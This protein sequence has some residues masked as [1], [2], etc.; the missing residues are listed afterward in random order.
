M[1]KKPPA[2]PGFERTVLDS[3]VRVVTETIP[4]VRSIAVGAWVDAGSRDETPDE[5]GITHFIEH[6]VFKGTKRRKGHH[7]NQRMESVGGYLNAFTSKEHTCFYARA[8]DHHLARSLDTTL[9]L[10]TQPTLPPKEVEKEKEVVIEEI[11]MYEDAPEDHIYDH[12]E[13]AMYPGHPLGRPVLGTPETVR[14]FTRDDLA[15]YMDRHYVP[16]RLV[17]SVAGHARHDD[18]VRLVEKQLADFDR[19]PHAVSREPAEAYEPVERAIERPGGQQAHL[20]VGARSFG[21]LDDRRTTLSVLNTILGGGMSSRLN[22]NIREKYGYCYAVYS[23]VN[24]VAETGDVGV[25]MGTDP[26]RLDRARHLIVREL[27]KLAE[28]PVSARMLARA[29]E[30][31]KGSVMLGIESMSNRMQRLGRVELMFER[32]VSLDEALAEVEAVTAEDVR[33]VAAALFAEDRLSTIA[34]VPAEA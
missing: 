1:P 25:Y 15:G 21:A 8:L 29:K 16:N 17:V 10:V 9:D 4:S 6:L 20:L 11:K 24:L 31:L 27:S 18:V 23:F 13:A 5:N 14:S 32:Y 3:G 2:V 33:E 12:Y 19:A 22:Q 30:Q 26:S 7:I 34:L 28:T